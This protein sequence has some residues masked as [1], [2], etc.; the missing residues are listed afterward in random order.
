MEAI[1]IKMA[2]QAIS[3]A[4]LAIFLLDITSGITE[5]DKEIYRA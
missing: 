4:E 1:G 3:E 2:Q 5:E